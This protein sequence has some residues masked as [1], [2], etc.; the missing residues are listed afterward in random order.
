[1]TNEDAKRHN[2]PYAE[3]NGF[4]RHT[5]KFSS[6]A[7]TKLTTGRY[8]NYPK[9][10]KQ[11]VDFWEEEKRR[12]LD[13]FT[14]GSV[15]V[16]GY[17]YFYLNY[18]R[19]PVPQANN[20]GTEG[21]DIDYVFPN[22]WLL[23]WQFFRIIEYCEEN[24]LHFGGIKARGCGYSE[25]AAAMGARDTNII[26]KPTIKGAMPKFRKSF[27][28]GTMDE[29]LGGDGVVDKCFKG[30]DYLNEET[31]TFFKKSF[32]I[33]NKPSEY[34]R[35]A[36][37]KTK[38]GRPQKTGGYVQGVIIDKTSKIRGK[39]G[40]KIYFE[41]SGENEKLV[42]CINVA[43]PLVE[44][45]GIVTG[46][47]IVWGTSNSKKQD[48]MEGLRQCIY[49][50]NGFGMVKFKNIWEKEGEPLKREELNDLPVD[51]LDF[52]IPAHDPEYN[53]RDTGIG[54]FVPVYDTL[55]KDPDGNPLREKAYD[56]VMMKRQNI[57]S[58]Q[59]E[60]Q[61]TSYFA[62]NPL[63]V[64]EALIKTGGK[65]FN[66]AELAR[67]LVMME[68]GMVVDKGI[69]G[70]F[71]LKKDIAGN[72]IG[73]EFLPIEKGSWVIKEVPEWAIKTELTHL[74]YV[75]DAM[76]H[77]RVP[78]QTKLYMAGIDS[79]DQGTEDSQTAGSSLACL[80]KKRLPLKNPISDPLANSY[81]AFFKERPKKVKEAYAQ[82]LA[83][84]IF[85]D[86][87]ALVEY[88]KVGI[89][90]YIKDQCKLGKYLA[91]EPDA[92]SEVDKHFKAKKTKKGIRATP[93]V[94]DFYIDLIKQ[95]LEQYVERVTNL[96]LLKQLVNYTKEKKGMFDYVA[97]MGMCE[98]ICR[99]YRDVLP[100]QK[101]EEEEIEESPRWYTTSEGITLFGIPPKRQNS[102]RAPEVDYYDHRTQTTVYR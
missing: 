83:A 86:A 45:Q 80:I 100:R 90:D 51:P 35:E 9:R 10:S 25:K 67:Q 99:E 31:E 3:A 15:R 64:S 12:C 23:D 96:S 88:T 39:R 57:L 1:M 53:M 40:Y 2:L 65:I 20:S 8:C 33:T 72:I 73:A 52:I 48:G 16:T 13:G 69:T 95:Y 82:V 41:E 21:G 81:V 43:R 58:G 91:S 47:I 54:W 59:S 29:H 4:L 38:D 28:F 85:F 70:N 32:M 78:K 30:I 75:D 22:F 7:H 71:Y 17:H 87:L 55:F 61:A 46:T 26:K 62:D 34:K 44:L 14:L 89:V 36:G 68:T 27:Y 97:A 92:P 50:P 77:R 102:G 66:T 98:L 56:Y 18:Y 93:V 42:E 101:E 37:I 84:L 19:M 6:A 49:N 60:E 74:V 63:T 76:H 94:I 24:G 79:I 5:I 11:W